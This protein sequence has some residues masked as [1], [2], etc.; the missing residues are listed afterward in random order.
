MPQFIGGFFFPQQMFQ[1]AWLYRLYK[2]DPKKPAERSEL[3]QIGK[4]FWSHSLI[5]GIG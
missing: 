1:L 3:D 2:L 4:L 5:L